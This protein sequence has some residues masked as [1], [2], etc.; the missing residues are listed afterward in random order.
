MPTP[1][2]SWKFV[3]GWSVHEQWVWSPQFGEQDLQ[4][5]WYKFPNFENI[6]KLHCDRLKNLDPVWTNLKDIF[7]SGVFL[8]IQ[9]TNVCSF[10]TFAATNFKYDDSSPQHLPVR[11]RI[12]DN[13]ILHCSLKI[14]VMAYENPLFGQINHGGVQSVGTYLLS[15]QTIAS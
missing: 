7:F 4:I 15:F 13:L 3:S 8:K 11:D 10:Y 9:R 2:Y 14:K 1:P 6:L 5:D 12:L